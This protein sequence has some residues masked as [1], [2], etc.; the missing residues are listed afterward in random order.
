MVIYRN[1]LGRIRVLTPVLN[2][3]FSFDHPTSYSFCYLITLALHITRWVLI[4]LLVMSPLL[5]FKL[6]QSVVQEPYRLGGIWVR[7][8]RRGAAGSVGSVTVT[9]V[10]SLSHVVEGVSAVTVSGAGSVRGLSVVGFS[11]S[12]ATVLSCGTSNGLSLTL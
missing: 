2:L 11:L 10:S 1:V 7:V 6:N 12:L 9:F 5:F 4:Q 8:L 3:V